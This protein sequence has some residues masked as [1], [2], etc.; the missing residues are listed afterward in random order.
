MEQFKLA[1]QFKKGMLP[2]NIME[3]FKSNINVYCTRTVTYGDKTLRYTVPTVWNKYIK[4]N[5]YDS[6]RSIYHFKSHFKWYLNRIILNY[7]SV[8]ILKCGKG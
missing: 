1:Y 3:F 7:K 4:L 2:H 6:I 5:N 8:F